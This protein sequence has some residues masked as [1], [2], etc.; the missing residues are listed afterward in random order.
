MYRFHVVDLHISELNDQKHIL[1][2]M[3]CY[4]SGQCNNI[5]LKNPKYPLQQQQQLASELLVSI[6]M[7]LLAGHRS[8]AN[9]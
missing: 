5:S 8:E 7:L 4:Y 2:V 3:T 1:Y 6:T 9:I